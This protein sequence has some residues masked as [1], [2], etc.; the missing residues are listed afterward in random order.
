MMKIT[1]ILL[2]TAV[3]LMA[4]ATGQTPVENPTHQ[5]LRALRTEMVEAIGKGDIDAILAHLHPDVVITWQNGVVC[6]GRD[7]TRD[8]FERMGKNAFRGYKQ[9]PTPTELTIL[10]GDDS[11]VSYGTS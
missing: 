1:R 6:K 11:G 5:E 4:P 9:A 10:H 3:T 2:L 8:F 7:G